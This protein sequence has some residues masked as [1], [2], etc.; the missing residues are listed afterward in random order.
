MIQENPCKST[1]V[2]QNVLSTEGL[3]EERMRGL[4]KV[5]PGYDK[6]FVKLAKCRKEYENGLELSTF[7]NADNTRIG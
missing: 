4:D 6:Y 2:C 3:S 5:D 1:D 7:L